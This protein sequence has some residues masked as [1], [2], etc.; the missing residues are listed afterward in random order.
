MDAR[1]DGWVDV[2][3]Y[4]SLDGRMDVWMDGW[5]VG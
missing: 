4:E 5:V 1:M 3:T 2:R